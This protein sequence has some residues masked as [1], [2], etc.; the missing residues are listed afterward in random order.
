MHP[1]SA[2]EPIHEWNETIRALAGLP[3][4]RQIL[5]LKQ[6]LFAAHKREGRLRRHCSELEQKVVDLQMEGAERDREHGAFAEW[7][8]TEFAQVT[9]ALGQVASDQEKRLRSV[10][11]ELVAAEANCDE[12]EE[13][14]RSL[15]LTLE[16]AADSE[17]QGDTPFEPASEVSA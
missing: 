10:R 1:S 2:L 14:C 11:L 16:H 8:N 9:R 6:E 13:T 17:S 5:T 15:L 3:E 12:L 4:P 7:L